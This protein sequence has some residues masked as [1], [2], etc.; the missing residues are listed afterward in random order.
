MKTLNIEKLKSWK[1]W[2]VKGTWQSESDTGQLLYSFQYF[3]YPWKPS[4]GYSI[5]GYCNGLVSGMRNPVPHLHLDGGSPYSLPRIET[6]HQ[7]RPSRIHHPLL[8]SAPLSILSTKVWWQGQVFTTPW[9]KRDWDCSAERPPPSFVH[10]VSSTN[11]AFLCPT[12][13]CSW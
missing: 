12:A 8:N 2:I 9:K 1:S 7:R 4:V 13:S 5:R 6:F 10:S 11:L 3:V